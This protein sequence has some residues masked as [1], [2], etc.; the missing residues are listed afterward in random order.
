MS[1]VLRVVLSDLQRSGERRPDILLLADSGAAALT[2]ALSRLGDDTTTRR[3][4]VQIHGAPSALFTKLTKFT[5]FT[6]KS[7][8]DCLRRTTAAG[9]RRR[10]RR[11]PLIFNP[12]F[13]GFVSFVDSLCQGAEGANRFKTSWS[14]YRRAVVFAG[15][16]PPP[17]EGGLDKRKAPN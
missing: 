17:A 5:K 1:A 16:R 11:E 14:S 10:Q 2:V 9:R 13:V 3:H 6:K 15:R 8:C 7:P 12:D 4:D